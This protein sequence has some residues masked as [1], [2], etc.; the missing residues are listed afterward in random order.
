MTGLAV[1]ILNLCVISVCFL[2]TTQKTPCP[3]IFSGSTIPAFKHN[4]EHT[5]S[6][7]ISQSFYFFILRKVGCSRP[8]RFKNFLFSMWSKPALGSTQPPIR[9]VLV[10]FSPG[11]KRQGREADHSPLTSAKVKKMWMYTSTPPVCLH[12]RVLNQLSTG[13]TLPLPLGKVG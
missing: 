12:G 3:A 1:N 13:K 10:A 5:G 8:G 4:G 7:A 11:V 6:K 9:W 2:W